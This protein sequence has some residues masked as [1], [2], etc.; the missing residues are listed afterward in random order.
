M[1][2][3]YKELDPSKITV[4]PSRTVWS[5]PA[6]AIARACEAATVCKKSTK[7]NATKKEVFT[8]T[9]ILTFYP[10]LCRRVG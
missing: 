8:C 4:S 5:G 7:I 1:K 3:L 2:K 9:V 6:S 10:V